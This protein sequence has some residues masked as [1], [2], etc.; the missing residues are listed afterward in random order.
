MQVTITAPIV[1][2]IYLPLVTRSDVV[3]SNLADGYITA[4]SDSV[5]ASAQNAVPGATWTPPRRQLERNIAL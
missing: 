4:A 1:Y 3:V 5:P 2:Y